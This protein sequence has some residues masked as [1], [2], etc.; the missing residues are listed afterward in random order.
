MN[1]IDTS[2]PL[3]LPASAPPAKDLSVPIQW[4]VG[5]TPLQALALWRR[6]QF[7]TAPG[8]RNQFLDFAVDAPAAKSFHPFPDS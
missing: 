4:E 7:V 5:R 8:N 6:E 2:G 3:C 1:V